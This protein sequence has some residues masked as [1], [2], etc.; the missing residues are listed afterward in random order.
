MVPELTP[1]AIRYYNYEAQRREAQKRRRP[2]W[3][4]ILVAGLL[5]AIPFGGAFIAIIYVYTH[6][7]PQ[8]FRP[9]AAWMSGWGAL[10]CFLIVAGLAVGG[11]RC[12]TRSRE[13]RRVPNSSNRC[14][15]WLREHA[16]SSGS[17]CPCAFACLTDSQA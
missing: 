12:S 17:R 16:T 10:A 7:N 15:G 8:A 14:G 2:A 11:C 9:G 4:T 6:N 13:T 3:K 1:E 5:F